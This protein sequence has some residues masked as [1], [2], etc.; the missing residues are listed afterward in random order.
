MP[1]AWNYNLRK[2]KGA[3]PHGKKWICQ[4]SIT[5]SKTY[6]TKV[7]SDPDEAFVQYDIL[8]VKHCIEHIK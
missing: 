6:N 3:K 7:V 5:Q 4:L 8:K 2:A 1:K